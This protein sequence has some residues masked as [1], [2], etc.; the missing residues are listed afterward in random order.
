MVTPSNPWDPAD[1]DGPA[2]AA[3][4][5]SPAVDSPE[6]PPPGGHRR[7]LPGGRDRRIEVRASVDEH[8]Q[9][10]ALARSAGV[11]VPRLLVEST[12]H[13]DGLTPSEKR[14]RFATFMAVRRTLA[15]AAT[16]LNQLAR[17]ANTEHQWPTEVGAHA[18]A[19]ARAAQ[20]VQAALEDLDR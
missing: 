10:V 15:G 8:A 1:P 12:L 4:R 19:V 9:L 16:N 20:A 7:R 13:A 2:L 6:G 17:W 3:L 14:A 18:E 11:S 5:F